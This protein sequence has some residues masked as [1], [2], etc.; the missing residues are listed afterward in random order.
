M[1][2]DTLWIGTHNG[3]AAYDL[4]TGQITGTIE[5]LDGHVVDVMLLAP[6][7]ALWVGS[8]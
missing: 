2:P 7:G 6:D 5:A 8:H 4:Q 3:L 1:T